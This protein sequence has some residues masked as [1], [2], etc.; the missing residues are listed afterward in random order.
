[1]GP[2]HPSLAKT[3]QQTLQTYW[4]PDAEEWVTRYVKNC[5]QCHGTPPTIK[6]TSSTHVTLLSK[7]HETQKEYR[8]TLEEWSTPHSITQEQGVWMKNGH[9][10]V[11]P[12]EE[13]RRKILQI[14]HDAP[15]A[16]HPGR[17]ETF[18]QVSHAYWWPGM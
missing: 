7:V 12:D 5:E 2:K 17:D 14:L 3:L 4:W 15:T 1:M 16:G 13:L 11:P 18:T 10:V 6:A 9:L 8:A